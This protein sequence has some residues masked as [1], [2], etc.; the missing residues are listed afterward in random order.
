MISKLR[1]GSH[2]IFGWKNR[3]SHSFLIKF[4]FFNC[5]ENGS[6][7]ENNEH[8]LNSNFLKYI[9]TKEGNV[10]KKKKKKKKLK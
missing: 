1:I 6:K 3:F 4:L 2:Q 10:Q 9:L 7:F 8:T 5:F